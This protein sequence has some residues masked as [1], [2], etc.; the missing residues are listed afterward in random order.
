[1]TNDTSL[2]IAEKCVGKSL[3]IWRTTMLDGLMSLGLSA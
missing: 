3:V 2:Q 1:M